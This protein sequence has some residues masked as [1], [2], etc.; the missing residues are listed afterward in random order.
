MHKYI[1]ALRDCCRD[2]A[3]FVRLQQ[4][5]AATGQSVEVINI[6][7]LQHLPTISTEISK[8]KAAEAQLHLPREG[9]RLLGEIALRIRQSLDLDEIL[10]TTV[11]EVRQFLQ[12]DRVFISK[13]D[14][15]GQGR[16]VAESV[17]SPWPPIQE[18]VTDA[19]AYQEIKALFEGDRVL[20]VNDTTQFQGSSLLDEYHNQYDVNAGI[21]IPII[22]GEQ[23]FGLLIANQCSGSRDWQQFEVNLLKQLAMQVA[24]AIQH[25]S[26]FQELATLN[27]NLEC[28]V[29]ERT[30]QLQEKM[31]ELQEL[32]RVKDV[33][34]HTVSHE[35]RTSVMG[36]IMVCKNLLSFPGESLSISR[37]IVE[38]MIQGSER[39]LGMIDSLL[40]TH[41]PEDSSVV[42]QREPVHLGSVLEASIKDL[43]P[44]LARS[45]ATLTN[46]CKANLPLI[47]ADPTQIQRIVESLCTHILKG[48]PPGLHLTLKARVETG[49]IRCIIQDNGASI[50]KVECDR[51][52]DLYIR[53]PQG[54][55]STTSGI[56]LYLCQKIIQAHGGQI[57]V[58]STPKRGS[59]FW[60]TLPVFP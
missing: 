44:L 42:L 38:R 35:L 14:E 22:L 7:G 19:T 23:L 37:S 13:F 51:L 59:T 3:A 8:H 39:Q 4:L 32:N 15:N 48:N 47:V 6:E 53:D 33:V 50:S 16:V 58:T 30:A 43:A 24:I 56:K 2:E 11:T 28:Q 31:Q 34:L 12:A 25:S 26:L 52:F 9:D 18:W 5:L 40:E 17:A 41:F 49:M 36:T 20:V 10:N 21:G 55:C 45:R 1:Q 54:K 57:G 46:Q 29:E 27:E 60:F